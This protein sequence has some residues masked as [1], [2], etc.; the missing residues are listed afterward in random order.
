MR[1]I[2]VFALFVLL[3]VPIPAAGQDCTGTFT[4]H[5]PFRSKC[6]TYDVRSVPSGEDA[7]SVELAFAEWS[8]VLGDIEFVAEENGRIDVSATALGFVAGRGLPD[9][10][11]DD[12]GASYVIGGVIELSTDVT[13]GGDAGGSNLSLTAITVHEIGHILIGSGH[14]TQCQSC[15]DLGYEAVPTMIDGLCEGFTPAEWSLRDGAN[16]AML[17]LAPLDLEQLT[18]PSLQGDSE[19]C[20][21][22]SGGIGDFEVAADRYSW[23]VHEPERLV[24]IRL[25]AGHGSDGPWSSLVEV[26]VARV[27]PQEAWANRDGRSH[28]RLV[29]QT[30]DGVEYEAARLSLQESRPRDPSQAERLYRRML[31]D[32]SAIGPSATTTPAGSVHVFASSEHLEVIRVTI[33]AFWS[34]FDNF[35]MVEHDLESFPA[36]HDARREAIRQTI[37]DAAS[38]LS[39]DR[40]FLLVGDASEHT[41]LTSQLTDWYPSINHWDRYAAYYLAN[42][43]AE[44]DAIPTFFVAD[45]RHKWRGV[46]RTRPYLTSDLPYAD[47]DDDGL[48]D[49]P[50][51]RW[52]VSDREDL[53]NLVW[54]TIRHNRGSD[55]AGVFD[56]LVSVYDTTPWSRPP[57]YQD[58]QA[59]VDNALA[60]RDAIDPRFQTTFV[61]ATED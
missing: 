52:P 28:V 46:A 29:A 23:T 17:T 24:T 9:C 44:N 27:G 35:E 53:I 26:P 43:P 56:A 15:V 51:T 48:P 58:T 4:T 47:I 19:S 18:T 34:F 55:D 1:A 14:F 25:E 33:L 37:R 11:V 60:A 54:R 7:T 42:N 12:S 50:V 22:P 57:I 5:G 61:R 20:D 21:I 3:A 59:F 38:D 10:I 16:A 40:R 13:W 8:G 36:Q 2:R 32:A 30:V 49:V 45:P 6:A 41:Q 39:E 31:Q